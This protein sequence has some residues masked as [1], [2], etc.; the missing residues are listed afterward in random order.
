MSLHLRTA[1]KEISRTFENDST[2]MMD[3]VLSVQK[4][5]GCVSD[6]SIDLIAQEVSVP[7]V[8]VESLVSFYS[9]LSKSPKEY[10]SSCPRREF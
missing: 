3:I 1:I 10:G 4:K 9:F 8:E 2:R 7:R 6:K 5:F